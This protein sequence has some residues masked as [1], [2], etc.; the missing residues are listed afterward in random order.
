[1]FVGSPPFL[2]VILFSLL[3]SMVITVLAKYNTRTKT[4]QLS[5]KENNDNTATTVL[6]RFLYVIGG[7]SLSSTSNRV[8]KYDMLNK[9]WSEVANIGESF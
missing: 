8:L 2:I 6:G 9:I 1:M 3:V 7:I 5:S 4:S